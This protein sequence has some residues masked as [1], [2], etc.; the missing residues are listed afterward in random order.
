[1]KKKIKCKV[2]GLRTEPR[3]E[4]TTEIRSGFVLNVTTMYYDVMN[5]PRCDCEITLQARH[6]L[7]P[8]VPADPPRYERS[9]DE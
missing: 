1:M 2:C 8:F 4:R 3:R 9:E 6:G 5:C 7:A